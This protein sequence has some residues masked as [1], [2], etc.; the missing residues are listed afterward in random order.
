[1]SINKGCKSFKVGNSCCDFICLDEKIS[2]NK[3]DANGEGH[4]HM[5]DSPVPIEYSILILVLATATLI[6]GYFLIL[7]RHYRG[8]RQRLTQGR[9]NSEDPKSL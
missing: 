2:L 8:R 7:C 4:P 3:T 5:S 1:M 6:L 9:N